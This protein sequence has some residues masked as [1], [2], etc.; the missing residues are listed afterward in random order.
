M[1]RA[2]GAAEVAAFALVEVAGRLS[3]GAFVALCVAMGMA[4]GVARAVLDADALAIVGSAF[5]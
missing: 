4:V 2:F 1:S 5:E 3:A